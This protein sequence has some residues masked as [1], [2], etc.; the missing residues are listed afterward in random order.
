[1]RFRKYFAIKNLRAEHTARI[2]E[3]RGAKIF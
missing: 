1:M 2:E 3:N